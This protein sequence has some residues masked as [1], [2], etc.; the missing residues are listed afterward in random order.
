MKSWIEKNEPEY[1]WRVVEHKKCKDYELYQIELI[2]QAW[3]DSSEVEQVLWKHPLKVVV[4][5]E[6]EAQSA[7]L[8]IRGGHLDQEKALE[9]TSI[10]W[11]LAC[12]SVVVE[13][14]IVPNQHLNF[15]DEKDVRYLEAGRKEDQIIAYTWDKYFKT[16]DKSWP[17]Q[18]PM[19]KAVIKAMDA[20]EEFSKDHLESPIGKFVV[21]GLSKR[22]WT[23]WLV[24]AH[25]ARVI[26]VI[27]MVIDLLNIRESF[28][29]HFD[30][31]GQWAIAI[32]DYEEIGIQDW[33]YSK[34]FS[35]LL[36]LVDPYHY[37]HQLLMPKYIV[38]ASGDEF[39]LPD[40]SQFYFEE[41][42]GLKYLR[43][44]PNCSHHLFASESAML[45]SGAFYQMVAEGKKL[46]V[47]Y[48]SQKQVGLIELEFEDLPAE[49]SVWSA[50]NKEKRDFRQV[51][52]GEV[53]KK[54]ELEVMETLLVELEIPEEG[55][56]ASFIEV[57]YP[58][59][60]EAPLIFTTD[61]YITTQEAGV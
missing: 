61:V 50:Y 36:D 45:S 14:S 6:V 15:K 12:S 22:G 19:T 1:S 34:E 5:G 51:E 24:A 32:K 23:S 48:W 60:Q 57:K 54:K 4:P 28:S 26:G 25:D 56:Q 8:A 17:L 58:S 49:V 55:W 3:R 11:A 2:S 46:P 30:V 16:G 43:Y 10:D 39:F 41:L 52:I 31:Y 42:E 37:R 21:S 35:S 7:L 18:V 20:V 33:I 9:Q 47:F 27:P 38:N 53:W 13:L 59:L 44:V 40:S 29:H